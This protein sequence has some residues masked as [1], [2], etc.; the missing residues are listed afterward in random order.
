MNELTNFDISQNPFLENLQ[1][2]C[3]GL[4]DIDI[5][6]N[7]NLLILNCS[8]DIFS[9]LN[10]CQSNNFNNNISSLNLSKNPGLISL[11]AKGN[12]LI[13]L[14][15]HL[16]LNLTELQCQNNRLVSLD[17]RN[18]NNINFTYFNVLENDSLYCIASDDSTW[19]TTNWNLI[20]TQSFF[21]N[22]CTNYY[23]YIPDLVFEQNLINL[24]LDIVVDGKVLTSSIISVDSL[25]LNPIGGAP[26]NAQRISDLTGIEDF[27]NLNYLNC[28]WLNLDTL[29]LSQNGFLKYLSCSGVPWFGNQGLA[30]K[31]INISQNTA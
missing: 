24:G 11:S 21:S 30:L 9:G 1:C 22:Y 20:P 2:R 31:N 16:N 8:N 15:I 18:G 27:V 17:V 26:W 25:T 12:E 14:D 6:Q 23:T 29:D 5:S 19:A 7:S 4:S 10:P 3:S 28:P 13:N